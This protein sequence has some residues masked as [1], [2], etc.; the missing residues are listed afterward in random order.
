SSASCVAA[1][2][3][4]LARVTPVNVFVALLFPVYANTS[5]SISS[6]PDSGQ[7]EISSFTVTVVSEP[8]PNAPASV[9][10]CA[11]CQVKLQNIFVVA[12]STPSSQYSQST[13]STYTRISS[14]A[15]S[16]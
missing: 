13:P 3:P 2:V 8:L 16:A 11:A 5:E 9:P 7:F 10:V 6:S 14:P 12:P 15:A 1:V 4:R